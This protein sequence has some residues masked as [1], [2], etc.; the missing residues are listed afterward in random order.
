MSG[1]TIT[2]EQTQVEQRQL[3]D[4]SKLKE[5]ISRSMSLC[6][7]SKEETLKMRLEHVG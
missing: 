7:M 5:H 3:N 4:V 6:S 2:Q 1:K